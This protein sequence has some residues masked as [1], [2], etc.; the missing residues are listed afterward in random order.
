MW[1]L[2]L[3]ILSG[4]V[5]RSSPVLDRE[6]CIQDDNLIPRFCLLPAR[7]LP[8][9]TT[10][11]LFPIFP[12]G[13]VHPPGFRHEPRNGERM[14]TFPEQPSEQTFAKEP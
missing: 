1:T 14:E 5:T 10:H 11:A 13:I 3:D 4:D 8:V 6:Y 12:D 9:F 7:L 2:N